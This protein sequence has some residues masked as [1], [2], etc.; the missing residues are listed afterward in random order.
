MVSVESLLA[1]AAVAVALVVIP[2]PG[3]LFIIGRSLAL[4]RRAGLLS[5]AG[6]A[7]G[8]IPLVGAVALGIGAVVAESAVVFTTVKLVGAGYLIYLGIQAIRHRKDH[9]SNTPASVPKSV[10]GILG[11][12]FIGGVT[13][14]K[15]AVFLVAVLP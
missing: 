11:Q 9:L 2:G 7:L 8:T 10:T 14:P 13:S 5:G 4:G 6:N 15:S 12:G 3:V 1:F